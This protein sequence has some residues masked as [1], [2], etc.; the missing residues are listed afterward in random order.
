VIDR[1]AVQATALDVMGALEQ[2]FPGPSWGAWRVAIKATDGLPM[3]AEKVPIFQRHTGRVIPPTEPAREAL[4][5]VG[6]RGGKDRTLTLKAV[7]AACFRHYSLA[8]GERG[9]VAIVAGDR[10]QA[11]V[12]FAYL[13][14]YFETVPS[15]RE[16]GAA[17]R[18]TRWSRRTTS[19]SK[20]APGRTGRF[21]GG[22]S[23]ASSGTRWRTGR[24]RRRARIRPRPS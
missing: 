18:A 13:S 16:L 21:V 1:A 9:V 7:V 6:R 10:A 5:L 20:F 23:C 22:R 19:S 2:H 12:T 3:T 14:A 24:M 8:P 4:Y 17:G 15:L 11:G